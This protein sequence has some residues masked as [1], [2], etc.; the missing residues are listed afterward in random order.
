MVGAGAVATA[1]GWLGLLKLLGPLGLPEVLG[2]LRL[3]GFL[4]LAAL[5]VERRRAGEAVEAIGVAVA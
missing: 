1:V 3:L 5:A 2:L 4:G